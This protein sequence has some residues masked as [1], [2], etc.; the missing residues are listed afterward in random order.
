MQLYLICLYWIICYSLWANSLIFWLV[1][2]FER[3]TIED[4]IVTCN[5]I[6]W[7][8]LPFLIENLYSIVCT[9]TSHMLDDSCQQQG[10][11]HF[12]NM[13]SSFFGLLQPL[14]LWVPSGLNLG[15]QEPGRESLHS[16]LPCTKVKDEKWC[17][18][19][20][21]HGVSKDSCTWYFYLR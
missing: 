7:V 14:V 19:A 18:S 5:W 12:P 6:M 9:V 20:V 3:Y 1:I 13:S 15:I 4:I 10:V 11:F 16:S 17:A 21:R 2:C 8:K